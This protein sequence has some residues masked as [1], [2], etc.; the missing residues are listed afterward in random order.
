MRL[1]KLNHLLDERQATGRCPT[2]KQHCWVASGEVRSTAGGHV[3]LHLRC[4][5]CNKRETT[6][7]TNEDYRIQ[8]TVI[9]NSIKEHTHR[10]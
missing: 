6:F 7:L 9:N 1:T 4:N 2:G 3:V 8:E 10:S 5:N